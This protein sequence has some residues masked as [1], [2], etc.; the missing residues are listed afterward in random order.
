MTEAPPRVALLTPTYRADLQRFGLLREALEALG[1]DWPHLA[2]VQ[3]EDLP[4]FRNALG[5]TRVEWIASAEVLPAEVEATR[6]RLS[7]WPDGYRKLRRSLAKRFGWFPDAASDGW[8]VQQIVKLAVPA[9]GPH[10]AY[11]A[12]DSDV[13][14][15]VPLR[16][17]H[18]LHDDRAA[19]MIE[20]QPTFA[21]WADAAARM[22]ALPAE[23][24]RPVNFVAWPFVFH[25]DTARGLHAYLAQV[26]GGRPWWRSLLG[27][28]PGELSEFTLYGAYAQFIERGR[29]HFESAANTATRFVITQQQRDQ[30]AALVE[31]AFDDPAARFVLLQASRRWPVEPLVPLVRQRLQQAATRPPR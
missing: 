7:G 13:L 1:C 12:L 28:R 22:L 14:P 9:I 26:H 3:T 24:V 5:A 31:A 17:E 15:T 6:R 21:H 10:T 30:A 2:V 11:V 29:H 19:L 23:T 20:Y 27:Q 8:H 16:A 25:R 18:Y 4:L